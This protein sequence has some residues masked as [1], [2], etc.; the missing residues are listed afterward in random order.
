MYFSRRIGVTENLELL[1]FLSHTYSIFNNIYNTCTITTGE[2]HLRD[3]RQVLMPGYGLTL[4]M[5]TEPKLMPS[6]NNQVK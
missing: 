2:E 4:F 6:N 5:S 3:N 1:F